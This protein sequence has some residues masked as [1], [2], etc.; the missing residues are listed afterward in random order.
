MNLIWVRQP[1]LRFPI[2]L[3]LTDGILTALTLASGSLYGSKGDI[4]FAFAFRIAIA[5]SISGVFVF[6]TAEYARLRA[7]LARA[8]KQL[9]LASHGQLATTELGKATRH[10]AVV[11]A[12]LSSGC[13][14]LGA[15]FP[16]VIGAAFPDI[17]WLPIASAVV[18][19][20]ILGAALSRTVYGNVI[21]WSAALMTSGALLAF[22]GIEIHV[23]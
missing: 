8:S 20:G 17:H 2:V 19:L 11:A 18:A 1:K 3:G 10:D 15:I 9:S 14:F 13:N 6:F 4:T 12:L 23:A 16:L 22:L 7:E 5:S 21:R